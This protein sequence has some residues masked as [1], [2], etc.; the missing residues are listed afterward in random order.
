M[1][2]GRRICV[3]TGADSRFYH[4]YHGNSLEPQG[5]AGL[6]DGMKTAQ[7]LRPGRIMKPA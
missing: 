4:R 5:L 3:E 6:V 2:R 1:P 7:R